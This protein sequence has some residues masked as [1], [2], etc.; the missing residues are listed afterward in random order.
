MLRDGSSAGHL[1]EPTE[2]PPE[3]SGQDLSEPPGELAAAELAAAQPDEAPDGQEADGPEASDR[4]ASTGS[5]GPPEPPRASGWSALDRRARASILDGAALALSAV[6]LVVATLGPGTPSGPSGSDGP[7]GPGAPGASTPAGSG[8]AA[9]ASL[10]P[11]HDDTLPTEGWAAAGELPPVPLVARLAPEKTYPRGIS[12]SSSFTLTSLT[13]AP[14]ADLAAGLT[15]SPPVALKITKG[16]DPK[17]VTLRPTKAL[18][19][20][21]QYR[22][23]LKTGEVIAGSWV[24]QTAQPPRIVGTLPRDTATLVPVD[25]GIELVFDQDGMQSPAAF[26]S[27]TPRVGGRWEQHGRGWVF[28]PERSLEY[29]TVYVVTVRHGVRMTGS[30]QVLADDVRIAFETAA[31]AAA[32][33]TPSRPSAWLPDPAREVVEVDPAEAPLIPFERV[34][35]DQKASGMPELR[36]AVHRFASLG[37]AIDAYAATRA[38]PRWARWSEQGKV[39]TDAL[40]LVASFTAPLE[41]ADDIPGSWV[42]FPEPLERGWYIVTFERDGRDRQVFLQVTDIAT[43]AA[44]TSTDTLVW[45]NDVT[46][47]EP[48]SGASVRFVGMELLGRTDGD[49]L[50]SGTTPGSVRKAGAGTLLVR[51]PDAGPL[52]ETTPGRA[53][54]VPVGLD[55]GKPYYVGS[56]WGW[57]TTGEHR[58]RSLLSIDRYG[59]RPTDQ[60]DVWGLV[61]ERATGAVPGSVQLRLVSDCWDDDIPAIS[62]TT[63]KVD[64][65]TGTFLASIPIKDLPLGGYCVSMRV[66]GEDLETTWLQVR[67]IV[68]PSFRL[69]VEADRHV[70]IDGDQLAITARATFFEDTPAA[71]LGLSIGDQRAVTGADGS[72]TVR[73]TVHYP[74]GQTRAWYDWQSVW[75][76]P[77]EGAEWEPTS[78]GDSVIVYPSSVWLESDAEFAGSRL[79][80]T[81]TTTRIDTAATEKA[82]DQDTWDWR[83]EGGPA[84]GTRVTV[85]VTEITAKKTLIGRIYDPI[86]K[87]AFDTYRWIRTERDLGTFRASTGAAGVAIVAVPVAVNYER[88]EVHVVATDSAGRSTEKTYEVRRERPGVELPPPLPQPNEGLVWPHLGEN[89]CGR[90]D[91]YGYDTGDRYNDYYGYYAYDDVERGYTPRGGSYRTGD[92]VQV[93]FRSREGDLM[94]EGGSNRYLFVLTQLGLKEA[95]VQASPLFV[96]TF[97]REWEPNVS[98]AAVRFT[99]RTYETAV[100]PYPLYYDA[101]ERQLTVTVASDAERYRPGG[102]ATVSV[103]AADESGRPVDATVFLRVI[104][105]RLYAMGLVSET[106]PLGTLYQEVG[107]GLLSVYATHL[108]PMASARGCYTDTGGGDTAG[109]GDDGGAPPFRD[110]FKDSLLFARVRTGSDGRASASFDLSDDLTSWRATAVAVTADLSAGSSRHSFAVGLP[111]FIEAPVATT[112]VAGDRPAIRV[113]TFGT[114]LTPASRITFTVAVP[115]LGLSAQTVKATGYG[116]VEVP[117]PVLTVGQHEVRITASMTTSGKT[118]QDALSRTLRVVGTRFTDQRTVVANL[119]DGLPA[120]AG[121]GWTSYLFSDAGRGRYLGTLFDLAYGAGDRLDSALAASLAADILVSRF[122]IPAKDLPDRNFDPARYQHHDGVSLLPYSTADLAL[123]ARVA[124]AA[125]DRVMRH[126]LSGYFSGIS[127][128]AGETRERRAIALAGRAALGDDVLSRIH[129]LSAD[130][131]LTIREQLYL[132]LGAAVLGDHVAAIEVEQALLSAY[133]ERFGQQLRLRVGGSLDDTL[134]ATALVALVGVIVGD[135]SAPLAEAYVE[136]NPGH[137]DLYALQQVAFIGRALERLPA[138]KASFAYTIDGVRKTVKLERGGCFWL[139]LTPAQRATL[140]AERL[141]GEVT[142][143]ATF[144]TAVDPASIIRDAGLT[145]ERVVIPPSPLPSDRLIKVQL[146]ATFGPQAVERCYWVTDLLPSGLLA[147]DWWW[148]EGGGYDSDAVGPWWVAGDRVSFCAWPNK[149]RVVLMEYRARVVMPGTYRWESAFMHPSGAPERGVLVP[150]STV[151]IR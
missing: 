67:Q 75:A 17:V 132:A 82:R 43:Y 100:A 16:R 141:T 61:R 45:V 42:S 70:L 74:E 28:V 13:D 18:E 99:G 91:W 41:E 4:D 83:P 49:G 105:E 32:G 62:T 87:R 24:F 52:D 66:G 139:R 151:T 35:E 2:R 85:Q 120:T 36:V 150:A 51:A 101:S 78:T 72:A 25:T 58:Y 108:V 3:L 6:V 138:A 147:A 136:A 27:I 112:L 63:P 122:D 79:N 31:K 137:D 116:S 107:S 68:K 60:I 14:A 86:A 65:A 33:T 26:F 76:Q 37:P 10:E 128:A 97:H 115:A 133:G 119:R 127:D 44:V 30:D 5:L 145:L 102:K 148:T 143:A 146:R 94:P 59:Y 9:E 8:G 22:F 69:S 121:D 89:G 46:T 1:R 92:P 96:D 21:R 57:D 117:L 144:E 84:S 129:E 98:L 111:F 131:A 142:V 12:P 23:T 48:V 114:A 113:R 39:N 130:P 64:K 29:A 106:E 140:S 53:A 38:A 50:A 88:H 34:P 55:T 11:P 40:A 15:A 104:D 20:G 118:Y 80:V 103:A 81:A 149:E 19:G 73:R 135:P 77:V 134:E 54:F 109:P 110:D 126:R 90:D 93:P 71:G 56:Y 123:S 124:L 47:E 125:P 7:T 95:R